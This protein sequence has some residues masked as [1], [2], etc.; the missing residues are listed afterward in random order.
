MLNLVGNH[1]NGG[2]CGDDISRSATIDK[3]TRSRRPSA[4]GRSN[5]K[6]SL[7]LEYNNQAKGTP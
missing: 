5:P 3:V 4:A 6:P 7:R 1:A 2:A